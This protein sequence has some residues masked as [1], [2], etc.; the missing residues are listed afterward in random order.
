MTGK[1]HEKIAIILW[2]PAT[3]ASWAAY[4]NGYQDVAVGI[5]LGGF[6]GWLLTPDIDV[7][8][9]TYEEY[10]LYKLFWPLGFVWQNFWSPYGLTFAHRGWSH[11]P[12]IGTLT[13]LIYVLV[14]ISLA[15]L[16]FNEYIWW[17]GYDESLKLDTFVAF[18]FIAQNSEM[19]IAWYLLWSFQDILHYVADKWS[20]A[21]KKEARRSIR[22][23]EDW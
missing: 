10:R 5:A 11:T 20:T 7:N 18:R 1:E 4:A 14:A 19:C 16:T 6:T 8:G 23:G 3:V 15:L 22:K 9:T 17:M 21:A 13:R 2:A 12:F